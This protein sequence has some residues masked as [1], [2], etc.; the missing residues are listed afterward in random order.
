[1]EKLA[2]A[3]AFSMLKTK[4]SLT[5]LILTTVP[6]AVLHYTY[7]MEVGPFLEFLGIKVKNIPACVSVGQFSEILFMIALGFVLR[8]LGSRWVIAVGCLSYGLRFIIFALFNHMAVWV[9]VASQAFHGICAAAF[10]AASFI[11]VDR[12]SD[13]DVR[14]SAQTVFSIILFGVGPILA[15][16]FFPIFEGIATPEG[17][18]LNFATFWTVLGVIGLVTTGLFALIFK[19]ETRN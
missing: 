12:I 1:V 6:I 19:D 10:F 15:G 3:K 13:S 11:Y 18:D 16:K 17:G 9:I 8:R 7:W 4:F 5:V 2:F 14:H